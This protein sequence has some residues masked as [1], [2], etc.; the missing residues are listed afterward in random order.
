MRSHPILDLPGQR[1]GG[2][3]TEQIG[4][5]VGRKPTELRDDLFKLVI[6]GKLKKVP[7][8]GACL[9]TFHLPNDTAQLK[10]KVTHV[11]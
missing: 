3:T 9:A 10:R 4:E 6:T 1:S 5:E 2:L 7:G 11:L 8:V